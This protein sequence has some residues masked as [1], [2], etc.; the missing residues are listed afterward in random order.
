MPLPNNIPP[1][2]TQMEY[3]AAK[4]VAIL[5]GRQLRDPLYIGDADKQTAELAQLKLR[6]MDYREN[7]KQYALTTV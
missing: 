7:H 4:R 2:H 6:L 1:L 3:E 5:M